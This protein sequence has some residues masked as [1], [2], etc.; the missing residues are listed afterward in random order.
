MNDIDGDNNQD[1]GVIKQE[2]ETRAQYYFDGFNHITSA[3]LSN[4]EQF[5]SM[6]YVKFSEDQ[7]VSQI[8]RCMHILSACYSELVLERVVSHP[9]RDIFVAVKPALAELQMEVY[10]ILARQGSLERAHELI[11]D[12]LDQGGTYRNRLCVLL[13]KSREKEGCGDYGF[14]AVDVLA[15]KVRKI[16]NL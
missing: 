15:G 9:D 7:L 3:L 1:V 6:N 16:T 2:L 4:L 14:E 11:L 8:A 12:I 5:V 10:K 13:E